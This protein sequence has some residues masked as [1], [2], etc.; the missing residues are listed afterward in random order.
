MSGST[1]NR[2]ISLFVFAT[3][4]IGGATGTAFLLRAP[5]IRHPDSRDP[6]TRLSDEAITRHF[7]TIAFGREHAAAPAQHLA[8]WRDPIR[9]AVARW[10]TGNDADRAEKLIRDQMRNLAAL[11]G[12][13]ITRTTLFEAN[14]LIA[15]TRESLFAWQVRRALSGRNRIFG[16]RIANANCAG[17]FSQ[18]AGTRAIIRARI[19]IPVDRAVR[20]GLLRRCI[21]EE[22]TQIMGLPNDSDAGVQSVFNDRDR[23]S[24]LSK[25]DELLV[26]ILYHPRLAAGMTRAETARAVRQILPA[27]RRKTGY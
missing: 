4:A 7:L 20:R 13:K 12:W 21:I 15:L 8:R 1:R 3:I 14:L 24:R 27:L 22:S 18:D 5:E 25:L 16:H 23:S 2:V 11:S 10:T 17:F 6:A 19:I 26:R 9:Y